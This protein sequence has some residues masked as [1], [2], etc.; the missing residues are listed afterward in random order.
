MMLSLLASTLFRLD[1]VVTFSAQA[2]PLARVCKALRAKTTVDVEPIGALVDKIVAIDVHDSAPDDVVRQLAYALDAK[3]ARTP[4]GWELFQDDASAASQHFRFRE[5]RARLI[6]LS[7]STLRHN[8]DSAS[9]FSVD[10]LATRLRAFAKDSADASVQAALDKIC[11]NGPGSNPLIRLIADLP[12]DLLA[13]IPPS[14]VLVFSDRPTKFQRALGDEASRCIDSAVAE[15]N[16]WAELTEGDATFQTLEDRVG[17]SSEHLDPAHLR[18]IVKVEAPSGSDLFEI[19]GMFVRP[20]GSIPLRIG[21]SLPAPPEEA[22]SRASATSSEPPVEISSRARTYAFCVWQAGRNQIAAPDGP[23]REMLLSPQRNEPLGLIASEALI[24]A[25]RFRRKSLV[26]VL[27]DSAYF[28]TQRVF[29]RQ[30]RFSPPTPSRVL[31]FYTHNGADVEDKGDW[32]VVRPNTESASSD[33]RSMEA[34]LRQEDADHCLRLEPLANFAAAS[35]DNDYWP[36]IAERA[37]ETLIPGAERAADVRDWEALRVWGQ[38][39]AVQRAELLAGKTFRLDD[40]PPTVRAELEKLVFHRIGQNF[41]LPNS[42]LTRSFGELARELTEVLPDGIAA[43]ARVS[44]YGDPRPAILADVRNEW[45]AVKLPMSVEDIAVHQLAD[46]NPKFAGYDS[47]VSRGLVAGGDLSRVRPGRRAE[48]TLD[49]SLGNGVRYTQILHDDVFDLESEAVSLTSLPSDIQGL[50]AARL[51]ILR[52]TL[53]AI[54][55]QASLT[56]PPP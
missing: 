1:R 47:F 41:A 43:D 27:P 15:Q 23:V 2:A 32:M 30:G 29:D 33:R 9:P 40:L 56:P 39:P 17:L 36:L 51:A 37:V 6:R 21:V 16:A 38:I 11:D 5:T 20:N 7:Q 34:L 31:D 28:L 52:Q 45:A 19:T 55:N 26:A 12:A 10:R 3:A 24:G 8:L 18:L 54:A 14:G 50:V 46:S 4:K 53:P 49:W 35:P 25:A 13:E 42:A 22:P 48:Y 44:L